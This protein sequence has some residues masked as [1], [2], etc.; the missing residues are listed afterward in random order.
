MPGGGA[1]PDDVAD[2]VLEDDRLDEL[3]VTAV[4]DELAVADVAPSAAQVALVGDAL[5]G[6]GLAAVGAPVDRMPGVLG[7]RPQ[8]HLLPPPTGQPWPTAV[9]ALDHSSIPSPAAVR[10]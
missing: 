8:E 5:R 7:V 1:E 3:V 10:G 9:V 6:A 4:V 2:G